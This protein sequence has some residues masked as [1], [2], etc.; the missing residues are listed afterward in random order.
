MKP[1]WGKTIGVFF[2]CW[3]L[4]FLGCVF[5]SMLAG[6][7]QGFS[8]YSTGGLSVSLAGLVCAA[9]Y[10]S[11]GKVGGVAIGSIAFGIIV[12]LLVVFIATQ[13]ATGQGVSSGRTNNS[14]CTAP[15]IISNSNSSAKSS[16]A[17]PPTIEP[18]IPPSA[19]AGMYTDPASYLETEEAK[20]IVESKSRSESMVKYRTVMPEPFTQLSFGEIAIWGSRWRWAPKAVYISSPSAAFEILEIAIAQMAGVSDFES[21]RPLLTSEVEYDRWSQRDSVGDIQNCIFFPIDID[22]SEYYVFIAYRT[23]ESGAQSYFD[24]EISDVDYKRPFNTVKSLEHI[25]DGG[26]FD[27]ETAKWA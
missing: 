14:G 26:L 21:V 12:G 4:A 6:Y 19:D 1:S 17:P 13:T 9:I 25:A 7:S 5:T 8:G 11:N 15:N 16:A 10:R 27:I 20:E 22:G 3:T 23:F 18:S 2:L 24:M